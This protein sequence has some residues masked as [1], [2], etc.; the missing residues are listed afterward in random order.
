MKKIILCA[1]DYGLN[2]GISQAIRELLQVKRINATSCLVNSAEWRL[3][4]QRLLEINT[5]AQVGLHLNFTEGRYLSCSDK[6]HGSLKKMLLTSH[7]HAINRR[8]IKAEIKAQVSEFASTMQRLPAFIDG[9]QHVHQLPVIRTCL[10]EVC[11]EEFG[12]TN[13]WLRTTCPSLDFDSYKR[14]SRIINWLGGRDFAKTLKAKG[15]NHNTHFAGVYDFSLRTPYRS[16][17]RHWLEKSENNTLI[18]CHPGLS[19]E[20]NDEIKEARLREFSYFNSDDFIQDLKN[21]Q[22][23]LC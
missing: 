21:S 9:H 8:V 10:L 16:L 5:S 17:F 4:A 12:S 22:V 3:E 19:C 13:F 6:A 11:Q 15:I 18:M 14:K 1:D 20:A 23:E 7:L 2:A